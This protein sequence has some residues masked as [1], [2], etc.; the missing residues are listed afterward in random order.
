[1]ALVITITELERAINRARRHEP[2][3]HGALTPDL[4]AMAELYGR[5]I[6]VHANTVDLELQAGH[7]KEAV[8]RWLQAESAI[9]SGVVED[10][11]EVPGGAVEE[12][13]MSSNGA[14]GKSPNW[15]R[16]GSRA[17]CV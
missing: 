7:F 10:S 13:P 16:G 6:F 17:T 2:V 4:R 11:A 5:M 14:G 9:E 1:M 8:S 3:A 15:R 12:G